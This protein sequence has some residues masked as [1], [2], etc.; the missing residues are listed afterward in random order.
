M[1]FGKEGETCACMRKRVREK[2]GEI[3]ACCVQI[4]VKRIRRA[5]IIKDEMFTCLHS[6][7]TYE[8]I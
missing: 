5:D 3:L 1:R 4:I 7:K 6:L 2:E 8:C